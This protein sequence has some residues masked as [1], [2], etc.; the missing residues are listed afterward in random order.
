MPAIDPE[1][2]S[3]ISPR[4]WWLFFELSTARTV[5]D[6]SASSGLVESSVRSHLSALAKRQ[7]IVELTE[8]TPAGET[9]Y[10]R[11]V[12][13]NDEQEAAARK[14][15]SS[16]RLTSPK[17]TTRVTRPPTTIPFA[18]HAQLSASNAGSRSPGT[19]AKVASR[20]PA[21]ED[22][23]EKV[24]AILAVIAIAIAIVAAGFTAS[25]ANSGFGGVVLFLIVLFFVGLILLAAAAG[26]SEWGK[27]SEL[28]RAEAAAQLHAQSGARRVP[29]RQW[30]GLAYMTR[31]SSVDAFCARCRQTWQLEGKM[32]NTVAKAQ[33]LGNR[34][35]R[36]GTKMEQF[37]ATFTAGASGR[38][39]AAGNESQRQQSE[40][41]W[42]LSLAMC[43]TCHQVDEVHLT[44]T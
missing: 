43:P 36:G 26:L 10:V 19:E 42:A 16:H 4:Q 25:T 12:S 1:V 22:K 18:F 28:R 27:P 31:A 17:G 40:L 44:R 13:L 30:R 23:S 32:A 11:A 33:G 21:G 5:S 2:F 29:L 34:L 39:I 24:F 7:V 9:T 3:Q 15:I 37:G 6:L 20:T 35:V 41:A 8:P 14:R 38:R